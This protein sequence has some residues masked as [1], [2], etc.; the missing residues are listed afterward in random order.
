V[1]LRQS[2]ELGGPSA[3]ASIRSELSLTHIII[4]CRTCTLLLVV[5]S[6]CQYV[7][8]VASYC[9]SVLVKMSICHASINEI[10]E[11]EVSR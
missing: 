10:R 4:T 11:F 2:R 3:K 1:I 7:I 9:T 5:M 6:N 8:A